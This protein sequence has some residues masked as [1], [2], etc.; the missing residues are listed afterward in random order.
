MDRQGRKWS[1]AYHDSEKRACLVDEEARLES[2]TACSVPSSTHIN[3]FTFATHMRGHCRHDVNGRGPRASLDTFALKTTCLV[4]TSNP[5]LPLAGTGNEPG[6]AIKTEAEASAWTTCFTLC[7]APR[8]FAVGDRIPAFNEM[9]PLLPKLAAL[10]SDS[11]SS[12]RSFLDS[13]GR[14]WM[15]QLDFSEKRV[16]RLRD[17]KDV[18]E[19]ALKCQH[20]RAQ[21]RDEHGLPRPN[22]GT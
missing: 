5:K 11:S 13:G 12:T 4:Q 1:V 20:K 21:D 15:V 8:P 17:Y 14:R 10:D 18:L 7:E 16:C 2:R 3:N 6:P 9:Q 19:R 22:S